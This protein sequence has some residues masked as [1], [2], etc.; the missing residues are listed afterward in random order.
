MDP[1]STVV[2]LTR[3]R[4]DSVVESFRRMGWAVQPD[5]AERVEQHFDAAYR[6][7][8]E[9][10]IPHTIADYELY[11][12]RPEEAAIALGTAIGIDLTVDDLN[13]RRE[14]DH[15]QGPRGLRAS[16]HRAALLLP[17]PLKRLI[18]RVTPRRILEWFLPELRHVARNPEERAARGIPE[19]R[20]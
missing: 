10:E 11:Q 16:L 12:E 4:P 15:S 2:I 9:L 20:R 3:R 5:L 1:E 8:F 18:R 7:I 14:L 17:L 13:V 19:A 6:T